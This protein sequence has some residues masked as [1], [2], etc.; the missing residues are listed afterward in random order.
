MTEYK[1]CQCKN[2]Y[3]HYM[4]TAQKPK[5]TF[6]NSGKHEVMLVRDKPGLVS[7]YIRRKNGEGHY[8]DEMQGFS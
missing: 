1:A 6:C 3:Q 7:E 4:S 2:C 5:C 8:K